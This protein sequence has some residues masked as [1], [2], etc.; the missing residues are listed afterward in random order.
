MAT[1]ERK[2]DLHQKSPQWAEHDYNAHEQNLGPAKEV[3]EEKDEDRAGKAMKWII[4]TLI[5]GLVI[6][7]F[8]F[9]RNNATQ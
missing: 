4:P 6:V 2:R 7:W 5:I 3:I 9:F 8:V 1:N